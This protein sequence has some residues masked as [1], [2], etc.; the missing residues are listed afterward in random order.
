MKSKNTLSLMLMI[1][2][3]VLLIVLQFLWL[4]SSYERAYFDFRRETNGLFRGTIYTMRDS[5]FARNIITVSEDSLPMLARH[6]TLVNHFGQHSSIKVIVSPGDSGR[7]EFMPTMPT[8]VQ[9]IS[10]FRNKIGKAGQ[11][12]A[13]IRL[14]QDSLSRDSIRVFFHEALNRAGMDIPFQVKIIHTEPTPGRPPDFD[15][16]GPRG[17][18]RELRRNVY[19][20]E[21]NTDRARFSPMYHYQASLTGVR[22]IIL[23]EILPQVLF[24]VFLTAIIAVAFVMMYRNMRVQQRLMD[25][26]NDF[27]S[28][29]THELKTPMAT[30]SVAL[31]ALKSFHVLEKPELTE[32][33]LSI[34]QSELNRLTLMTD[35][36]LKASSFESKGIGFVPEPVNLDTIIRKILS[37][38]KLIFEKRGAVVNYHPMGTHF[39]VQGSDAHLTNVVYNLVDNALKYGGPHPVIDL[40]LKPENHHID[41]TVRD[42]GI[43]IPKA[44]QKKIFEKFFRVPTGDIHN[45]KGYGLGLSYVAGVIKG[46]GGHIAV[47]SEPGQ[48]SSFMI[49]LPRRHDEN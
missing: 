49:S 43:G 24:S 25:M 19:R 35:K 23:R 14:N 38:M 36:I 21:I 45:T 28:N 26:K 31:E 4:K 37:S 17:N 30:V 39:T 7:R 22:G 32:E 48:G 10:V 18:E 27:I 2:S 34:A 29:I 8:H 44:Y 47:A 16:D 5:L 3:L 13:I 42:R 6:D 1:S 46:H 12:F 9:G 40:E 41:M 11:N 20:D 33:Y 15:D